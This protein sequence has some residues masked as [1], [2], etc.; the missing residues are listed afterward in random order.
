MARSKLLVLLGAA[1]ATAAAAAVGFL[2]INPAGAEVR[3]Q[4]AACTGCPVPPTTAPLAAITTTTTDAPVITTVPLKPLKNVNLKTTL[5][6]ANVVPKPKA[7]QKGKTAP[8]GKFTGVVSADSLSWSMTTAN[9]PVVRVRLREGAGSKM[10][11]VII[12]LGPVAGAE[13]GIIALSDDQEFRLRYSKVF[14]EAVSD[15]K[16]GGEM[17]GQIRG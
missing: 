3:A 9:S 8:T 2:P 6:Q 5:T 14:I 17:R 15:A 7:L 13:A 4:Q 11:P 1:T 16:P 12:A 10:G